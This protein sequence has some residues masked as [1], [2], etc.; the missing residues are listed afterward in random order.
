MYQVPLL[1]APKENEELGVFSPMC[2]PVTHII[3]SAG[4][5]IDEF[6]E[7][8]KSGT[9]KG[10]NLKKWKTALKQRKEELRREKELKKLQSKKKQQAKKSNTDGSDSETGSDESS[11]S[12]E[13]D[14]RTKKL[15]AKF[16]DTKGRKRRTK[17]KKF[18]QSKLKKLYEKDHY[19][20][21]GLE[22]E[23]WMATDEQIRKA[24]RKCVLKWHPDKANNKEDKLKAITKFKEVKQSFEI[25]G[26]K[27]RR[28]SYDSTLEID[29]TLPHESDT[30]DK[31]FYSQLFY[32]F[33]NNSRWSDNK[34]APQ[35]GDKKTSIE[36]VFE[37]YEFWMNFKSWRDFSYLDK[38]DEEDAENREEKRWMNKQNMRERAK[39]KKKENLRIKKL[40]EMSYRCDPR[41][42]KYYKEQKEIRDKQRK[43]ILQQRRKEQDELRDKINQKKLEKEEQERKKKLEEQLKK[44]KENEK[45]QQLNVAKKKLRR[46]SK[47]FTFKFDR[48]DLE[49]ICLDC[50]FEEFI[51]LNQKIF[52]LLKQNEKGQLSKEEKEKNLQTVKQLFETQ[53]AKEREKDRVMEEKRKQERL[54]R[55]QERQQSKKNK[56]KVVWNTKERSLLSKL[57][58]QYPSGTRN[59]YKIIASKIKTKSEQDV[60]DMISDIRSGKA[61][62]YNINA[63]EQYKELTFKK[64]KAK[65]KDSED[66]V[67]I[68]YN[69]QFKRNSPN[70]GKQKVNTQNTNNKKNNSNNKKNNSDVWSNEQ[71]KALEMGLQKYKPKEP[72]RWDKITAMV[73]D[74]TKRQCILRFKELAERIK[75]KRMQQQKTTAKK[76]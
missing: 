3:D 18:T 12:S 38:Y 53:V 33:A 21:L 32:V 47:Y 67:T 5:Y 9:I 35:L 48:V 26:N 57:Y 44:K 4:H 68:N 28:K 59:R 62:A 40:V 13:E 69:T 23:K 49:K 41:I 19:K 56:V 61:A 72:K 51:E 76:K 25:L 75:R 55:E 30:N 6:Y 42:K 36:K 29:D 63:Y 70:N 73:P 74:K 52:D 1:M 66:S 24:Y 50:K 10:F 27:E 14:E 22:K 45:K 64:N 17:K 16:G 43:E 15:K 31:N 37:F 39:K 54:K 8:Y 65:K 7:A 11:S 60:I 71:Q 58:K 2:G 20:V 46:M 34:A